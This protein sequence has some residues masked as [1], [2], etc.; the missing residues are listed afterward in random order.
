MRKHSTLS[1]RKRVM[2]CDACLRAS[3]WH[4]D[5]FCE[6]ARNAGT[7]VK[8]VGTLRKLHLEHEDN[9]S[10]ETMVRI[11]GDADRAF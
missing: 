1:D 10:D 9:W 11:Y 5:F 7:T 6:D 4:G 3:C 2:V 8:L